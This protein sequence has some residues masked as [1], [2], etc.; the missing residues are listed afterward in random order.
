MHKNDL[1]LIWFGVGALSMFALLVGYIPIVPQSSFAAGTV[2]LAGPGARPVVPRLSQMVLPGIRDFSGS[3]QLDGLNCKDCTF[4]NVDW[5]YSGG[6]V[7]CENCR[8]SGTENLYVSGAALNTLNIIA[9]FQKMNAVPYK[10]EFG[11]RLRVGSD[12]EID[13]GTI[14]FKT[15]NRL[16]KIKGAF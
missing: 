13:T 10:P 2:L 7:S 1:P 15:I 3:A 5:E 12:S 14:T 8:F 9:L 6:A 11:P 4:N 16:K